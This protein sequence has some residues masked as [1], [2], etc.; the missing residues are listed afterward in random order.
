MQ[1]VTLVLTDTVYNLRLL[2]NVLIERLSEASQENTKLEDEVKRLN[3]R[4][5]KLERSEQKLIVGQMAFTIDNR[6]LTRVMRDIDE[7][8]KRSMYTIEHLEKAIKR[9]LQMHF[10]MKKDP[11]LKGNGMI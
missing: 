9:T 2:V 3:S 10:Q 7:P 6:I 1:E 5:S 11:L 8:K 4:I